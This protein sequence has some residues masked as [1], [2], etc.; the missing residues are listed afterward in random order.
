LDLEGE[1]LAAVVAIDAPLEADQLLPAPDNASHHPV[2][3]AAIK[4]LVGPPR[5]VAGVDPVRRA[6]ALA[7]L[8]APRRLD[9]LHVGEVVDAH[10]QL[11]QVQRQAVPLNTSQAEN[12]S[13]ICSPHRWKIRRAVTDSTVLAQSAA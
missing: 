1:V 9:F 2:E 4:Q 5:R 3:R 10:G 8:L 7:A 11:D 13:V 12:S 6:R